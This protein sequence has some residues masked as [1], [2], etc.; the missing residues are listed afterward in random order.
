MCALK[1]FDWKEFFWVTL[2][3]SFCCMSAIF[4]PWDLKFG[5]KVYSSSVLS[6]ITSPSA[7]T[8]VWHRCAAPSLAWNGWRLYDISV[9]VLIF[10][11][12]AFMV[13]HEQGM[14]KMGYSL[15]GKIKGQ[16][17]EEKTLTKITCVGRGCSEV[18]SVCSC[19]QNPFYL[20]SNSPCFLKWLLCISTRKDKYGI[21]W[22]L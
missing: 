5:T 10:S 21:I 8:L 12:A 4:I 9:C 7:A 3:L 19:C 17:A 20:L 14:F 11:S 15:L 2:K 22:D 18:C 16:E 13:V 1:H 6:V